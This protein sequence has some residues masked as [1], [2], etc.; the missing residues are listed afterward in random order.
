MEREGF[1]A[2]PFYDAFGY[3]LTLPNDKIAIFGFIVDGL[4]NPYPLVL[5]LFGKVGQSFVIR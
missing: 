2:V 4:R 5:L 1:V 3:F